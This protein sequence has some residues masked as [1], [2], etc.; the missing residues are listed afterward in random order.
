MH[1]EFQ[2]LECWRLRSF[3]SKFTARRIRLPRVSTGD[4]FAGC[5]ELITF[6][7]GFPVSLRWGWER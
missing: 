2:G 5:R 6:R 7:S 3:Y 1:V 4:T